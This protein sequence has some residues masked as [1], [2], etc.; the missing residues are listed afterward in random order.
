MEEVEKT[1][2]ENGTPRTA[3]AKPAASA[4][5][6]LNVPAGFKAAGTIAEPY[7]NSGWAKEI[8]HK[9][10]G[11]A[12]VYVPAGEFL[13]G[14]AGD[15]KDRLQSETQHR[16]TLTKGFYMGKYEVT[17][18]QWEKAMGS[19]PS[20]FKQAGKDAPVEQVSSYD[21]QAFCQKLG[22]GFRLP[23]EAEWEYACRAGTK[24]PYAGNLGDMA[25]YD[26]NS[27]KTS[28]PVGQEQP[29]AWGLYDMHGN[30]CEWCQDW[31]GDYP[32]GAVTDPPGPGA[33]GSAGARVSRGGGWNDRAETCRSARRLFEMGSQNNYA[34]GMRLAFSP[35]L[36]ELGA[37]KG[38]TIPEQK[39]APQQ[40]EM[41][42]PG[43]AAELKVPAGFK[44]AEGTKPEPYTKTGWAKEI[45]HEK[46]GIVLVY[47]PAGQFL[48]GSPGDEAGRTD[49][50][51]QHRIKLTQGFYLGK[52]EVTQGQWEKV[53]GENPSWSRNAGKD[54]PVECVS[55]D[56]CQAFCRK[57]DAFFRL[58][59]EAEWEYACRAGT[60]GPYAENLDDMAWYWMNSGKI[61]H[62]VGQKQ[63][64]AWGLYDMHGNVCEWCR[65]YYGDYP[66][67]AVTDPTGPDTGS[68]RV[69]RGGSWSSDAGYCRSASRDKDHPG[70]K[71]DHLGVRLAFSL[72]PARR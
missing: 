52:Y 47:I 10:T 44:A 20:N 45:I 26:A 56:D 2:G 34:L 36:G 40:A 72:P 15:E 70:R 53:M 49:E 69:Y 23:T 59:T 30:V 24:G 17:Q 54:A 1:R 64:N 13:M 6:G 35:P 11:I 46:T 5:A 63:P 33:R 22:A 7:T 37:D 32:A 21:C 57:L 39:A 50:E 51:T 18:G 43:P 41:Q 71:G 3:A 66:A 48:M 29:N 67:G 28:H 38:A 8:V 31:C 68:N 4:K 55:W 16:V 12:M 60:K 58:P 9:K 42:P 65:D 25:W 62:P 27:G 61:T 14:S 19:N